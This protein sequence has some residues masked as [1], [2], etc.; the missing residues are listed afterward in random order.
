MIA[1]VG[2]ILAQVTI[3]FKTDNPYRQR[4][5]R[6]RSVVL[7]TA[8]IARLMV[9]LIASHPSLVVAS[10]DKMLH[11]NYLCLVIEVCKK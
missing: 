5:R 6:L 2:S 8:M 7:A 1:F 4:S 3:R 9:K 10:L 11:D